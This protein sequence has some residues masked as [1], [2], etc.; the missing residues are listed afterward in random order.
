MFGERRPKTNKTKLSVLYYNV[1]YVSLCCSFV[2]FNEGDSVSKLR[3]EIGRLKMIVSSLLRCHSATVLSRFMISLSS[4][5]LAATDA[6]KT[7]DVLIH[8]HNARPHSVR[9]T[10]K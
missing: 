2:L 5:L 1:G 7:R 6:Q 8:H 10:Q 4:K 9:L 3:G